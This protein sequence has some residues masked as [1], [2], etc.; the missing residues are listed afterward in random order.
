M[1]NVLDLTKEEL[2]AIDNYSPTGDF[3][4]IVIVPTGELHE[5]GFQMMKFI[6]CDG[7]N[8]VGA[9]SGYSDVLHLDGI[10]GYGL[11]YKSAMVNMKNHVVDWS[12]DLLPKSGCI[13]LFIGGRFKRLKMPDFYGSDFEIYV[14]DK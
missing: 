12:I 3:K 6:L 10:G 13:R 8:V 7:D 9:A 5:S 11:D 14:E 1:I 4:G 2:L